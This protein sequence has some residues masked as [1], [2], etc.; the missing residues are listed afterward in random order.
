MIF[1]AN[2]ASQA[3]GGI[4]TG[5][6]TLWSGAS[7]AIPTGW[8]LCN[9]E[10]GTPDLRGRFIVGAGDTYAV[11]DTGGSEN[12]NLTT[13]N[14]PSHNHDSG[15]LATDEAGAHTHDIYVSGSSPRANILTTDYGYRK[16]ATDV[17]SQDGAHTHTI[18]GT[19]GS[20]G[21]GTAHENRPPY[22]AL[23]YIMKIA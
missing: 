17:I 5:I 10:N 7:D 15:T 8:A 3:G 6:I 1:N 23:C 4:P 22:Y 13:A 19:T 20:T 11:G 21:S 2:A 14:L 16:T 18:S 12:V 9:G